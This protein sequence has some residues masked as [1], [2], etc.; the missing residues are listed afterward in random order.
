MYKQKEMDICDKYN[1]RYEDWFRGVQRTDV[2]VIGDGSFYG[3][4][5]S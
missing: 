4:V 2:Y 3:E 5:R 1:K